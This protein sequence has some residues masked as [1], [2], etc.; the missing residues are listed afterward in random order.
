MGDSPGGGGGSLYRDLKAISP[1][2]RETRG[3]YQNPTGA[4]LLLLTFSP[5]TPRVSLTFAQNNR[6]NE[7]LASFLKQVL[8]EM[9]PNENAG[10]LRVCLQVYIYLP[11]RLFLGMYYF[12]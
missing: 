12:L 3:G 8:Q 5:Q 7:S 11:I 6:V 9:P 2:H 10:L 1:P 4:V